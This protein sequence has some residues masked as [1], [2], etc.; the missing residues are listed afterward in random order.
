MPESLQA[1]EERFAEFRE[2]K[3]FLSCL[4]ED[5]YQST[6]VKISKYLRLSFFSISITITISFSMSI[7]VMTV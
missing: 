3:I 5:P 4:E 6:R 1:E 2:G 7:T